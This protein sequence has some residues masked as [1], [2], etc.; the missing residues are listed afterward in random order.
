MSTRRPTPS[1]RPPQEASATAAP[2]DISPLPAQ[3]PVSARQSSDSFGPVTP[4]DL[5]VAGL[6]TA[7]TRTT[8][9]AS[10]RLPAT[11]PSC[12]GA[13]RSAPPLA[14]GSSDACAP[15]PSGAGATTVAADP[16]SPSSVPR[17]A[18][19]DL[20]ATISES[21]AHPGDPSSACVPASCGS[22]RRPR[23]TAQT[24]TRRAVVQTSERAHSLPSPRVPSFPAPPDHGRT[25]PLP[26]GAGV[27]VPVTPQCPYPQTQFAETPG[28]NL[29]L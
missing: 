18:E 4:T 1:V 23:S 22:R 5:A 24:A 13:L 2:Q 8:P 10:V 11:T 17:S 12:A 27:A 15:A 28:G 9:V 14:T 7:P 3:S 29:L 21:A 16:D 20:R 6:P 26:H 25:S 19:S